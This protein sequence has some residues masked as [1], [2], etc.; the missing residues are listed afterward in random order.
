MIGTDPTHAEARALLQRALSPAPASP[1]AEATVPQTETGID[2]GR[3][4]EEV[5]LRIDPPFVTD[6]SGRRRTRRRKS[7]TKTG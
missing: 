6:G 3:L 2:W 7:P 4:E 5:G 1:P